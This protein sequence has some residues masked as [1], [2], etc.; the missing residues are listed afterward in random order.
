MGCLQGFS[1][2]IL[3]KYGLEETW[4]VFGSEVLRLGTNGNVPAGGKHHFVR[5]NAGLFADQSHVDES[6]VLQ[7]SVEG[8]ENVILMVVPS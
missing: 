5:P 4:N 1:E 7:K 6:L 3:W 8:I 2:N